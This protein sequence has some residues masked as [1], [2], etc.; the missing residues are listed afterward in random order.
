MILI[1]LRAQLPAI[2]RESRQRPLF[3]GEGAAPRA[4]NRDDISIAGG[5][6]QHMQAG[7][8]APIVAA[9]IVHR[10]PRCRPGHINRLRQRDPP[11]AI[12][13]A[14]GKA[15]AEGNH[16]VDLGSAP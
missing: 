6:L 2:Q 12:L 5:R 3:A 8:A 13:A 11:A 9:A 16:P 1:L 15:G 4:F 7:Q 10:A 14:I